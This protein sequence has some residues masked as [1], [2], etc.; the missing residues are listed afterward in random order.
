MKLT[1]EI[2]QKAVPNLTL[3][4]ATVLAEISNT[5]CP[6][7]GLTNPNIYHEFIAN[8]AHESGG[9]RIRKESL[10]YTRPER[11]VAVWPSRFTLTNEPNKRDARLW[12]NKPTELAN[13]VYGG[14][15]GNIQ[16]GDGALFVGGGFPQL[17]GRDAYTLYTRFL[18]QRG[19]KFTIQQVAKMIQETDQWAFDCALWF[20][21]EFKNLENLSLQ[22]NFREVVRRWNG[23]FVGMDD[24]LKYYNLA[25]QFIK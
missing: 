23:G 13:L 17:T 19:N 9:F 14:R 5:L 22:D 10:N 8:C 7:Y 24:R 2:F 12:T 4:R 15:M 21:C 1:G 3:A 11:R 20:F 18:N 25:K 6:K 16:P